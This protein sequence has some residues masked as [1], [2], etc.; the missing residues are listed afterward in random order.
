MKKWILKQLSHLFQFDE[1]YFHINILFKESRVDQIFSNSDSSMF[2]LTPD[3]TKRGS[4]F[5]SNSQAGFNNKVLNKKLL[6]LCEESKN[7]YLIFMKE[8]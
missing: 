6:F 5:K 4:G 7:T 1:F 2:F 8:N 3:S